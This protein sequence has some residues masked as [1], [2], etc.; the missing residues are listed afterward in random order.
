MTDNA[1]FAVEL[2]PNHS[3]VLTAK[4]QDRH[5]LVMPMKGLEAE[6]LGRSLLL[7][8]A[9]AYAGNGPAVGT[10]TAKI[11]NSHLPVQSFF[12][13]PES[14]HHNPVLLFE[15]PGGAKLTF[16]LSAKMAEECG[17]VL[18]MAGL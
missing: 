2:G 10:E 12:I 16:Q 1:I 11:T 18:Y 14:G 15:L 8:G 5:E 17:E 13:D 4:F 6:I 7:A 9:V 3:V